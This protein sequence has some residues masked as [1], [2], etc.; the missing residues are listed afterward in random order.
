MFSGRDKV[1]SLIFN[2]EGEVAYIDDDGTIWVKLVDREKLQPSTSD[3][4]ELLEKTTNEKELEKTRAREEKAARRKQNISNKNKP[5]VK[6]KH[7]EDY[8]FEE[9]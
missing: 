9:W 7:E 6:V 1:Y 8:D 4:L 3:D 5:G 2:V